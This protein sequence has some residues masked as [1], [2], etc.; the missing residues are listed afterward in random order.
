[1]VNNKLLVIVMYTNLCMKSIVT[2]LVFKL[3][4]RMGD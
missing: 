3:N 4:G 1:M 2:K